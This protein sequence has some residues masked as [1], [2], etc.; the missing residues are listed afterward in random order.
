MRSWKYNTNSIITPFPKIFVLISSILQLEYCLFVKKVSTETQSNSIHD[1]HV[2]NTEF[3]MHYRG[4]FKNDCLWLF[5]SGERLS[6]H[7]LAHIS[8]DEIKIRSGL[9]LF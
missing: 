9:L 7:S 1:V 4:I 6:C 2:F 5:V 3:T 8:R